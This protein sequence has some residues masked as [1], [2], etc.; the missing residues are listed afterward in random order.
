MSWLRIDDGFAEH[1]KIAEL[2][3]REFRVWVRV[4]CYAAR[5]NGRAGRLTAPMRREIV[6]F[7]AAMCKR[8]V[9]LGL[10]DHDDEEGVVSIHDWRTYNP[11]DPAAADRMRQQRTEAPRPNPDRWKTTR[12][13][14]FARDHGICLDCGKDCSVP[15]ADGRDVWNADH[16]PHR[17]VLTERGL[18]IYDPDYI[19]TRCHS[20]HSKKT[21]REA[22]HDRT[23][24]EPSSEPN[25]G[26]SVAS[27]VGAR[28][29]PVPS[30]TQPQELEGSSATASMPVSPAVVSND[31]ENV[32]AIG[33]LATEALRQAGIG[34]EA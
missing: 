14:V 21:R 18:S 7:T 8:F 23:S 6:G 31:G 25:R 3:D 19:V 28:A 12:A 33:D 32:Y 16:E 17:A 1:Y 24:S 13:Q 34:A 29:R 22:N 26:G 30:P 2:T 11:K 10:L 27:R 20:C 15:S 9:T 5:N 4:L